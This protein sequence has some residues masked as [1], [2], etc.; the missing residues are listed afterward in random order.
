VHT[1]VARGYLQED[2]PQ[3]L[4]A[5]RDLLLDARVALHRVSGGRSDLLTLQDQDAVARLVD[6]ADADALV[7]TLGEAGRRVAWITSDLWTRL[8]ASEEGPRSRGT[9]TRDLGDGIT[10]RDGRLAYDADAPIDTTVLLELSARAAELQCQ[11]ERDTLNRIAA[12]TDLHWTDAARD[13]FFTL[14]RTGRHAIGVFETL[15]HVGVLVRLLPEWE[16]VRARPQRNAYHRFTVDRHSLEA[17]S[18][19]AALLDPNDP[20][21]SG[22]DGDV[23]RRARS[24][25]LLLAA[26]LHD[27]GKGRRG[28]HSEVGAVTARELAG[29]IRLDEDG[30]QVVVWLVQHHLLLADTATRRDVSDEVTINRF[31]RAVGTPEKLDLLYGLTIGDSRA[32][33]PAAWSTSKG[34]LVRELWMKTDA[35]F[36]E[37]TLTRESTRRR[38]ELRDVVGE[39]GDDFLDAMPSRYASAFPVAE[40][41]HHMELVAAGEFAAEWS[42]AANRQVRCTIVAADR[43]GMLATVAGT[44]SLLGVDIASASGY[45]HHDGMAIE[46]FTGTDRFERLQ[47]LDDQV[48][49]TTML[50]DALAG[51]IAL[52]EQLAERT[53]RYRRNTPTSDRDVQ[54]IVDL[55]A[56]A[57]ATVVEVHAPDDVGVLARVAAVFADLDLDVS[58]AIVATVGDRVVDVFYVRDANGQKLVDALTLERLR[59]TVLTRL[60]TSVVLD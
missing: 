21:G 11:F 17:V 49:A 38:D 2:D 12:L 35:L 54:V 60:T 48:H 53:R 52:D 19:C 42:V 24:D 4:A 57:F 47:S 1:L 10:L 29:R 40:I 50:E 55:E 23:A 16:H 51:R 45:S 56:A 41:A 14:L 25:L 8:L 46:V 31:A 28:D 43:T 3:L 34:D 20:L 30:I 6:A 32:T 58:Q 27:I 5:A 18:E 44:L 33:G 59:A 37:G 7:R 9:G 39:A 22:F 15:D 13:W 36:R 26:M